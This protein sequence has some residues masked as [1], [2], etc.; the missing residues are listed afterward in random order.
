MKQAAWKERRKIRMAKKPED[1]TLERRPAAELAGDHIRAAAMASLILGDTPKQVAEMY[2]LP[3][4]TVKRMKE[5]FDITSPIER[6]DRL[7]EALLSYMENEIKNLISIGIVTSE[8]DWIKWQGAGE[9]A[10]FLRV[11]HEMMGQLLQSYGRAASHSQELRIEQA[12][13]DG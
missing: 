2:N 9:L 10:Q 3:L 6:R 4:A 7:S 1:L 13:N 12:E 5:S 11:K 8:E